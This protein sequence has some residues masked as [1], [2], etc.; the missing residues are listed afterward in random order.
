MWSRWGTTLDIKLQ[1]YLGQMANQTEN[2]TLGSQRPTCPKRYFLTKFHM[3]HFFL[4]LV[5]HHKTGTLFGK[6][7]LKFTF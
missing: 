3:H 4:I 1:L 7:S 2:W 5:K 6:L